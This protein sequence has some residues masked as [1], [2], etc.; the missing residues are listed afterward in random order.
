MNREQWQKKRS[1]AQA[2]VRA[3]AFG[4]PGFAGLTCLDPMAAP[5]RDFAAIRQQHF[6]DPLASGDRVPVRPLRSPSGRS[7]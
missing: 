3:P 5:G 4:A 6:D 1:H 7:H 2:A